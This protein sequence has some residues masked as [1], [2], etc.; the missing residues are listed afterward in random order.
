MKTVL[1]WF[2]SLLVFVVSKLP[3][4]GGPSVTR[5]VFL[6]TAEVIS[7]GWLSLVGAEVYAYA[8]YGKAD[9]I[10]CGMILTL[11]AGL[12]AFAQNAQTTKLSLDS[13]T[14]TTIGNVSQAGGTND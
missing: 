7:L 11:G 13:K 9:A 2:K 8:R 12:F 10:Y 6:R 3:S 14:T 4:D 1:G 5:W